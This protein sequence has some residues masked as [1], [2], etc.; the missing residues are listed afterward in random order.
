V[1]LASL[2]ETGDDCKGVQKQKKKQ[3]FIFLQSFN[4]SDVL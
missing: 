3:G 2:M 1:F 4:Q